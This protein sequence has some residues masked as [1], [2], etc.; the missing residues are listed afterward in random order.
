MEIIRDY[1]CYGKK[2]LKLRIIRPSTKFRIK[3]FNTNIKIKKNHPKIKMKLSTYNLLRDFFYSLFSFFYKYGYSFLSL[4]IMVIIFI[5][6]GQEANVSASVSGNVGNFLNNFFIF[7]FILRIF[8]I[9]KIAHFFL[10]FCLGFCFY[11]SFKHLNFNY[12]KSNILSVIFS[13]L[14]ACSDEFHQLFVAGRSAKFL[15]VIIDTLGS[16]TGIFIFD[17]I[18]NKIYRK[19]ML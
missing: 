8:P 6:S 1:N 4:F 9:R 7:K 11:K 18:K 5:F 14:Y 13:F 17:V 3:R 16:F 2:N 10:Y 12:L 19:S 15:D